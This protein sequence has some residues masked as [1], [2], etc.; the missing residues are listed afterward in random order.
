[1]RRAMHVKR[2]FEWEYR[3][4]ERSFFG[5]QPTGQLSNYALTCSSMRFK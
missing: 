4:F 2:L 1:M 3:E 5:T